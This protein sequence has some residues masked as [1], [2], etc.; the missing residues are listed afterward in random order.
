M[1]RIS[2]DAFVNG[3]WG[4]QAHVIRVLD[5][6]LYMRAWVEE[7]PDA[8]SMIPEDDKEGFR[9]MESSLHDGIKMDMNNARRG[10]FFDAVTEAEDYRYP[11]YF[12]YEEISEHCADRED[13][14]TV[15]ECLC[16]MAEPSTEKYAVTG[17]GYE[18]LLMQETEFEQI[19]DILRDG[20]YIVV[21]SK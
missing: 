1:K 4:E 2:Y 7:W 12:R 19:A 10:T 20:D 14:K 16:S 21:F 9:I 8:G 13:F 11:L 17:E 5:G 15:Y 18:I 3:N 6:D